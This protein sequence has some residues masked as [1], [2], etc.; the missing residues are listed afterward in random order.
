MVKRL[1]VDRHLVS[2]AD[3]TI[4]EFRSADG[5]APVTLKIV[6]LNDGRVFAAR[7]DTMTEDDTR[8][9]AYRQVQFPLSTHGSFFSWGGLER[10]AREA[11]HK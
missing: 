7:G 2:A 10:L 4:V 1:I 3:L 9:D 5:T 6:I 8:G 11:Q